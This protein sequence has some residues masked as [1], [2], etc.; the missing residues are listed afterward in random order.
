MVKEIEW[1]RNL[2]GNKEK[3]TKLM[4]KSIVV[5]DS[6]LHITYVLDND[7]ESNKK[8][9]TEKQVMNFVNLCLLSSQIWH[10]IKTG[11]W[12]RNKHFYSIS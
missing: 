6:Y 12:K 10:K 9:K 5:T 7:K 11:E 1:H 2:I 8:K 3:T 4:S